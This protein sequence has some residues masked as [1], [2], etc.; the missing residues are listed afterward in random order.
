M[1]VRDKT[2][3]E[4]VEWLLNIEKD[5]TYLMDLYYMS[6]STVQIR[7]LLNG[8]EISDQ[9]V[10][11]ASASTVT[12]FDMGYLLEG[13]YFVRLICDDCSETT[14]E[15]DLDRFEVL[16][17]QNYEFIMRWPNT[18]SNQNHWAQSSNPLQ[19]SE[20][21]NYYPYSN[22]CST[23][24]WRG[25]ALSDSSS[26][27]LDGTDATDTW[28]SIGILDSSLNSIPGGCGVNASNV[29]LWIR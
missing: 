6:I 22:D 26:V 17:Q 21:L 29:E 4:Y 24:D 8:N 16:P 9:S 20:V 2:V 1:R 27:L 23:N 15:I 28:Y 25:L 7:L 13:N 3:R 18:N 5:G 11:E 12:T 14:K 19:S 10:N